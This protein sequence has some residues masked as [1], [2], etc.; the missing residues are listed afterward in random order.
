MPLLNIG[1]VGTTSDEGFNVAGSAM[2]E[3]NADFYRTPSS[4]GNRKNSFESGIS[5]KY[6]FIHFKYKRELHDDV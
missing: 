4:E 6:E 1:A 2:L 3:T 5:A